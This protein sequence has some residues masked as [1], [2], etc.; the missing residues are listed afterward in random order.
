MAASHMDPHLYKH[1][2]P[3]FLTL[4]TRKI[5]TFNLQPTILHIVFAVPLAY[6][7]LNAPTCIKL[8]YASFVKA[9]KG[10]QNLE[11]FVKSPKYFY[12]EIKI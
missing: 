8:S 9:Y 2:N 6:A 1:C 11:N 3:L 5:F 4:K 12:K 10:Y 7:N